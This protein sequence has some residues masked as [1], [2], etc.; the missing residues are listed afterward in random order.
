M[1]LETN[2]IRYDDLGRQVQIYGTRVAQDELI[3]RI[4]AVQPEHVAKFVQKVLRSPLT[5]VAYGNTR[6]A[7]PMALVQRLAS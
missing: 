4:D 1:N 2:T 3:R 6:T 7:P 5:Y